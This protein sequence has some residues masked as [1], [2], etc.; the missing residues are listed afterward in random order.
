MLQSC[1]Y[2]VELRVI[3]NRFWKNGKA[4]TPHSPYQTLQC[5]RA[6]IDEHGGVAFTTRALVHVLLGLG[7]WMRLHKR[8]CP[9]LLK[10]RPFLSPFARSPSLPPLPLPP[11]RELLL[12]TCMRVDNSR[13]IDNASHVCAPV[14]PG[15]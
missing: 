8:R 2:N 11:T 9:N 13:R 3:W 15:R 6:C 12:R 1:P 7:E 14:M 10:Q 4:L 5:M